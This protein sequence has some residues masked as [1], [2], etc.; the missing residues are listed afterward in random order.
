MYQSDIEGAELRVGLH[1]F[2]CSGQLEDVICVC[3]QFVPTTITAA[4]A[5]SD[6]WC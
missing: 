2:L 3:A 5:I 1:M 6:C 4:S